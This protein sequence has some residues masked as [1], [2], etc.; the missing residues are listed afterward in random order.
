[1]TDKQLRS[2][3]KMQLLSLLHKQEVELER[4]SADNAKLSER[5]LCLEQAGSLAE[6]SIIVSGIVEATQKAADVYLD[7]I[8][9]AEAD[10]LESIA[11]LEEEAKE[12]ALR[13][14]ELKNAETKARLERLVTDMLR[15]FDNQLNNLAALKDELM[16]LIMKNDIEYLIPGSSRTNE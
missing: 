5:A 4:L 16:E 10:K 11:K 1:M 12:R 3:S 14:L 6:A 15:M 9:K 8:Q 7:S 2:L 13:T